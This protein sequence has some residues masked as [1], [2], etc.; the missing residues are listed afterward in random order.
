MFQR[1]VRFVETNWI[2]E[3]AVVYF[4]PGDTTTRANFQE[5]SGWRA[6]SRKALAVILR[7]FSVWQLD[8]DGDGSELERRVASDSH[9]LPISLICQGL[10]L[11]LCRTATFAERTVLEAKLSLSLGL[12]KGCTSTPSSFQLSLSASTSLFFTAAA[13]K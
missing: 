9:F 7:L 3:F 10:D 12:E 4:G 11:C 5:P 8:A 2:N 13:S 6:R 1:L